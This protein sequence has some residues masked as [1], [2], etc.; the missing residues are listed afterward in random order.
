[1]SFQIRPRYR[2]VALAAFCLG[3]TGVFAAKPHVHGVATLN[4]SLS[5][6][7]VEL[8]LDSPADNLVG[9]EHQPRNEGQRKAVAQAVQ[10]LQNVGSLIGFAPDGGCSLKEAEIDSPFALDDDH[11]DA[12]EKKHDHDHDDDDA[13]EK[14][15]D[16]DDDAHE[17][18][19]DHDHDDDAHEKKH[20]HDHDHDHDEVHSDFEAEYAFTCKN[21]AAIQRVDLKGLFRHF[22]NFQTVNVSWVGIRGQSAAR[23]TAADP[24]VQLK[25]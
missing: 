8:V 9:F 25:K 19:H 5:D 16:H 1:M 2:L 20:D 3:S 14:K 18:K 21:A 10:R 22:P 4:L 15:H 23:A 12:H 6:T 7:E 24:V 11:D 17:K 13:H